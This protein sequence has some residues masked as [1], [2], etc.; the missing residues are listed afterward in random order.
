MVIIE[1]EN[2]NQTTRTKK[3]QGWSRHA[4]KAVKGSLNPKSLCPPFQNMQ[5]SKNQNRDRKP[6]QSSIKDIKWKSCANKPKFQ[7][8]WINKLPL[9]GS[10]CICTLKKQ[11]SP[12]NKFKPRWRTTSCDV[13]DTIPNVTSCSCDWKNPF[14]NHPYKKKPPLLRKGKHQQR[15]KN[16]PS[17]RYRIPVCNT[18]TGTNLF[19]PIYKTNP[20]QLK[21]DLQLMDKDSREAYLQ[22]INS[23]ST[24]H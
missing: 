7:H 3:D 12:A 11:P 18:Q 17:S 5:T 2:Y 16:H 9:I 4:D 21:S 19:N 10:S 1:S 8:E 13:K 24:V 22:Q 6:I 23:K 14:Y 15:R 20:S